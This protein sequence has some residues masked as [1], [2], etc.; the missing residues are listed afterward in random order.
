VLAHRVAI[1][2]EALQAEQVIEQAPAK[3]EST[4]RF[5]S[6]TPTKAVS[7]R[8]VHARRVPSGLQAEADGRGIRTDNVFV[9]HLCR[10]AKY[11]RVNLKACD[12][13]VSVRRSPLDPPVVSAVGVAP[14]WLR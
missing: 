5:K 7:S 11:E 3:H 14:G 12:N 4:G 1:T 2:L 13:I 8:R 9:E 6:S 10:S